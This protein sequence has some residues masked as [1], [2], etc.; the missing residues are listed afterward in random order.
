MQKSVVVLAM[1][2]LLALSH[3]AVAYGTSAT[4]DASSA[5]AVTAK[6]QHY[7]IDVRSPEEFAQGHL[8]N[9]V[10]IP[11][12]DVATRIQEITQDKNAVID[13][14]CRSGKRAGVAQKTLQEMGFTKV[15]N[16]GGFEQIKSEGHPVAP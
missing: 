2:A 11:V 13:L 8:A 3:Q 4:S 5:N 14:Y 6:V 10:N 12:N 15:Q 1:S 16:L 7:L 9:A